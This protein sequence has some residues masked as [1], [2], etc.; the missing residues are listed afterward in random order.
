MLA[1]AV[2]I[3]EEAYDTGESSVVEA[4]QKQ[5][6]E[7]RAASSSSSIA[8]VGRTVV[9]DVVEANPVQVSAQQKPKAK[10]EKNAHEPPCLLRAPARQKKQKRKIEDRND[11]NHLK[12]ST[13]QMKQG[14][15][16]RTKNV[17][18]G[19]KDKEEKI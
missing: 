11:A 12:K 1:A 8:V 4:C 3:A 6:D 16:K 7:A 9:V 13:D 15:K 5:E 17:D 19:R 14:T 2:D 10:A 18:W